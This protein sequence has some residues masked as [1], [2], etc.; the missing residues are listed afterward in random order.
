MNTGLQAVASA[1]LP[2][3]EMLGILVGGRSELTRGPRSEL[4]M[5]FASH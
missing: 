4:S 2:Q 3:V 1:S 5:L